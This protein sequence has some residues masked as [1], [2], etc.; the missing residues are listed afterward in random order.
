MKNQLLLFIFLSIWKISAQDKMITKSGQI[1]FEASVPSFEEVKAKT[2]SVSC[3]LNTKTGEIA[4]LALQ[5]S[6]NGRALQ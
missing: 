5:N 4:S 3:I 2:E 1:I 6:F